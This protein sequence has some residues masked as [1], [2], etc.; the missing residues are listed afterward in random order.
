[1]ALLLLATVNGQVVRFNTETLEHE[2]VFQSS[3][4][5]PLMGICQH[6]DVLF[7]ASLSRVYKIRRSDFSL[8][9]KTRLYIPSPDFHQM[10]FY[11]GRLY[12]TATK[13]NQ[14]WT[15]NKNLQR[16]G[17]IVVKPPV[18]NRRVKYKKNYN[19]I[20]SIVKYQGAFYINLNWLTDEQYA[21]S[22]VLKTNEK[23]DEIE[24]FKFAWE[25]HDF[26]FADGKM[27]AICSTSGKDKTILHPNTSGLMVEGELVW[28]HD[29]DESFCK[30]LCHD[31]QYIFFCGGKKAT[32]EKRKNTPGIIYLI[33]KKGYKL[34]K[35]ITND[36]I[37]GVRGAILITGE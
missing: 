27:M 14:I 21:E 13:K 35:K 33:D 19:H 17:K 36:Q 5:E 1:M 12:T 6:E 22:G 23:F 16:T 2:V 18:P 20:N 30:A 7:V 24:K 9:K 11:N 4:D 34:V 29:P 31:D 8:E 3:E 32:R 25:S 28:K 15:Y 10:N 37:M 26:Q